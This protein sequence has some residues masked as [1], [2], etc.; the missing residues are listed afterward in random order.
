MTTKQ[1]AAIRTDVKP[2]AFIY[3][4]LQPL[5]LVTA[6][7]AAAGL[8]PMLNEYSALLLIFIGLSLAEEIWPARR[9]WK[10]TWRE[11]LAVVAMFILSAAAIVLWQELLYPLLLDGPFAGVRQVAAP[12]WPSSLPMPVQAL[13]AFILLQFF[14]YWLHRF[15]H[16]VGLLWRAT[17]HGVHHTY[18]RLNAINWNSNHPL[19]AVFLVA[20]PAILTLIFGIGEA[21]TI[22]V[23]IALANAACAH[24]NVRVNEKFI[25]LIFTSNIHHVHHHSAVMRESNTNFGCASIFWDRVFGTFE[26]A[27]TT[28]LGDFPVEPTFRE[29]LSLPMRSSD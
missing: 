24:L 13:L 4:G 2:P 28:R 17:G 6:Y 9:D 29:K 14:A 25:G 5:A 23:T 22:A 15:Q 12:F 10:Q 7:C 18:T 3:W 1:P 27:D 16:N 19:E 21:A 26:R 11:R 8:L 20:P